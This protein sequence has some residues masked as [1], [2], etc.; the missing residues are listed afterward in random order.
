MLPDIRLQKYMAEC[1]VASRRAAEKL[2]AAGK[3]KING[4]IAR[5]GAKI[6]PA[7]DKVMVN[8][9]LLRHKEK[10]VYL[11]LNKPIGV[12]SACSDQ[13]EMT[14][15]DLIKDIPGR[16]YPVGRLDMGSEG[17]MILTNDG[18]LADRLMHPRYEHEKEYEVTV[19]GPLTS[20]QIEKL[21]RGIILDSRKTLPVKIRRAGDRRFRVILREGRKRQIRR[22]MEAVGN[23]VSRLKRIRIKNIRLGDLATGKYALLTT[24]EIKGL[25]V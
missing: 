15:V 5:I 22:M 4:R 10:K 12:V 9:K 17:L 11:K 13:K 19:R 6:D 21:E 24:S 1:G 3:V 18:E 23:K 25:M 14:V 2:I 16:L 7:S 20:A 8:G